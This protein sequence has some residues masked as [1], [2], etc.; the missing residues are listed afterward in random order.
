MLSIFTFFEAES[1]NI[2]EGISIC[3]VKQRARDL[4]RITASM[5]PLTYTS[6]LLKQF[7]SLHTTMS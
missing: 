6:T 2:G 1:L 5:S 7:S 4:K 3:E